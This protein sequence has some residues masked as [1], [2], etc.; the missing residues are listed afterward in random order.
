[1]TEVMER[2]AALALAEGTRVERFEDGTFAAVREIGAGTWKLFV[3]DSRQDQWLH[4]RAPLASS[5][6]RDAG[7]FTGLL[8]RNLDLPVVSYSIDEQ[9]MV[10]LRGDYSEALFVDAEFAAFI[11]LAM[12][13][14]EA[15]VKSLSLFSQPGGE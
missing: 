2:A 14:L 4:L 5:A 7:F 8:R 1:M 13:G 3:D 10:S 12:A 6:G 15:A 9:G 11:G